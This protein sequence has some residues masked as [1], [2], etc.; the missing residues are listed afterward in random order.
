MEVCAPVF[1]VP[2]RGFTMTRLESPL[3]ITDASI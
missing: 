3:E 1:T 2:A